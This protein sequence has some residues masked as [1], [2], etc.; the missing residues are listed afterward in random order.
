MKLSD[1]INLIRKIAHSGMSTNAKAV[2]VIIALAVIEN[3]NF[4]RLTRSTIEDRSGL[5]GGALSRTIL[6]LEESCLM[7]RVRTGRATIWYINE[8]VLK[9]REYSGLSSG[10]Q[11][12]CP[13]RVKRKKRPNFYQEYPDGT[14]EACYDEK[15]P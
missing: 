3:R 14:K 15:L 7:Y 8:V 10:G 4:S 13:P 1:K 5:S 9:S 12:D 6:E 11:S 2:G